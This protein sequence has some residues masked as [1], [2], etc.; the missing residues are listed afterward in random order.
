MEPVAISNS[1]NINLTAYAVGDTQNLYVIIINKTHRTTHDITDAAVMIQAAGFTSG[2]AAS[3]IF[4][5]G[6]PGNAARMTAMLGGAPITNNA[7]WQG[8][9]MPLDR[10]E[11]DRVAVTVPSTTAVIVKI[12]AAG[13]T[14]ANRGKDFA[15]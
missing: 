2:S 13:R 5:D 9:W 12:H 4:T 3:M 11:N 15:G 6:D 7:P 8:K 14:S 1:N 10:V